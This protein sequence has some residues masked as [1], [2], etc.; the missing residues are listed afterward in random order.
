MDDGGGGTSGGKMRERRFCSC[1]HDTIPPSRTLE[2]IQNSNQ[3][4][5][6]QSKL[7]T[8]PNKQV[9]KVG[10]F[11]S[12]IVEELRARLAALK[13]KAAN[14]LQVEGATQEKD[15][16]LVEAKAIGEDYLALEK[17]VNLNYMVR[18]ALFFCAF[19]L[20]A[21]GPAPFLS[22]GPRQNNASFQCCTLPNH[23]PPPQPNTQPQNNTTG[24]AQDPQEAR[25]GRR[26]V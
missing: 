4:T 3:T 22:P 18:A 11:T 13:P 21:F 24:L 10:K 19:A 12:G 16:L 7:K 23:P 5:Q 1:A 14:A 20:R 2:H 6:T 26:A 15:A 17:F 8:N 9:E 25:Q